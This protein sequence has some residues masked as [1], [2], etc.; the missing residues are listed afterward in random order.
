MSNDESV[1]LGLAHEVE[2]M[3]RKFGATRENFWKPLSKNEELARRIVE[4]VSARPS[5]IVVVDYSRSLAEMI[6]A[7]K[8]D[9][10]H[11]NINENNFPVKGIG[12]HEVSVVLFHFNRVIS[13][14]DAMSEMK[15]TGYRP[16]RIEELLALGENYPDLQRQFPIIALRSFWRPQLGGRGVPALWRIGERDLRLLWFESAWHS[17]FRFLAVR[18]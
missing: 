3:L 2:V 6:K 18:A 1:G 8:Y 16:A 10:V 17:V 14:E 5:Y 7:G 4:L 11:G 15:R 9:W 13:S 12:R